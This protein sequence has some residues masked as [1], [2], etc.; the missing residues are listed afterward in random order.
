MKKLTILLIAA[1]A[2][3]ANVTNIFSQNLPE[4]VR[5]YGLSSP[6]SG[7][8]YV[9]GFGLAE[10]GGND[11]GDLAA[12]KNN[13]LEDLIRKI[14][15]QVSSSITIETAENKAGSTTSVAMKSRSISSMKLSNVQY[16]IAKD[17]KFYYALA[18]VAKNTLKAAYAGKGKD[19]VTYILQEKARAE[20]DE[21]LG[22][23]KAAIDRYV[24]LLPYFAEVMDNRSL[25]NV[26]IDGA[27]GNEFFDTAG[28]GEVRS[29]DALFHLESTV[30]SRLDALGKGSVAN[31]DTALDKILAMLLT[32][33]V[34][35]SSLQIPPFLYQNSDFTSAFGRYVAGRLEN[36]AGSKLAG[37]KAKVAIR[38]TYWEK[39]DAIELMVAAKS[40]DTGENLGTGFAQFPAHAV[41]SQFDIKPMNAEEALRTQYALADGAIVDGGLRVDVWT[42]R[43][44]DEDVLV[45][46]EG[47]SLE[48]FFKVNQ[49][50]FLQVTYDLATGQ[51]V[52]LE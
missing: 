51:K 27:P 21:A 17:S 23:A 9:T 39:G 28:T 3:L 10:K 30:R 44:R 18:F 50:A 22:N 33:Q 15:V 14:R 45:F 1:I 46:S 24:K 20:N 34:K 4:W 47:E 37:G 5:E 35:G 11:A 25:F 16:E 41:P 19:A 40:A 38:G 32:Q 6:Y 26:M 29:A 49:P 42:N 12:A 36:L 48:F 2:F 52:L 7:R 8:L 43:G 13:A 31:L